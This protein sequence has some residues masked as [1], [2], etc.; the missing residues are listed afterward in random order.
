MNLQGRHGRDRI[1]QRTLHI[2][3]DAPIG[4]DFLDQQRL[5]LGHA[6]KG[7]DAER[8]VYV[9]FT[10]TPAV[11]RSHAYFEAE[12]LGTPAVSRFFDLAFS[13]ERA[14]DWIPYDPARNVYE[15]RRATAPSDEG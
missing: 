1:G 15:I 9:D 4:H 5:R 8:A 13:G 7:F 3:G 12:A 2:A 6:S 11:G 10:A 14:E